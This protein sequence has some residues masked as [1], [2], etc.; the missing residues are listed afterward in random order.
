MKKTLLLSLVTATIL[1]TNLDA[2]N[3]YDRIQA[4]EDQMKSLQIKILTL[5]ESKAKEAQV[6]E[7]DKRIIPLDNTLDYEE[8]NEIEN[9]L[10]IEPISISKI[11]VD[12]KVKDE[13]SIAEL[14]KKIS[15]LNRANSANHLKLNVDYRYA[16]DNINYT[17]SDNT[18]AKSNALM[19]NRLLINM[20][21]KAT[22]NLTF[23]SQLAY[24]K[25]FGS[26]E[27]IDSI[28]SQNAYDDHLR[29]RSAY[30]LWQEQTFFGLD[31]P[32]TFSAGRH[33]ST[34]GNLASFRE[35]DHATSP[36]GH[37]INVELDGISS[38]FTLDK[39]LG[40]SIKICLGRAMSNASP[41]SSSTPY[42]EDKTANPAIDIL[43][44]IFVPHED[45]QYK[46]ST[47]YYYAA[48]L[49]DWDGTPAGTFETVGGLHAV[50]GYISVSGIGTELSDFLDKTIL[51]ASASMSLT[52]PNGNGMLG[53]T[54][55]KTGRSYWI[56]TQFPSLLSEE[57]SWGVEYNYGSKY[58]RPITYGEDTNIG[59]KVAARGNAY[60]AYFTEY[61]VED[62][63][64][65]QVRYTYIDYDYTGSNGFFGNSTGTATKIKSTTVDGAGN[66]V[67]DIA[68]DIRFYIRY[69]Y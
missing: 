7:I 23:E 46:V 2:K 28:T 36:T 31:I 33:P 52:S 66:P 59:S 30:L 49:I 12:E 68:Q 21:Y 29:V 58:W 57:G 11:K 17:M 32:W 19:S 54:E 8:K 53:T 5:Q 37:L 22:N 69:K 50:N 14:E 38:K 42:A 44:F 20:G 48:N 24:N 15:E 55:F 62:I 16:I 13:K 9:E 64:S 1:G 63:L 41:K 65:L 3:M 25:V 34:G 67:V 26:W 51:F 39:D 35:D 40:G 6:K 27:T 47:M 10:K 45:K 60:E 4:M 56:G 61:L 43:G 18:T